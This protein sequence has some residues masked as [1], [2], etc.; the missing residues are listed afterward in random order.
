[1]AYRTFHEGRYVF[2][3]WQH[4]QVADI[5][6]LIVDIAK[7]RRGAGQPLILFSIIPASSDPPSAA[8]RK[9]IINDWATLLPQGETIHAVLEGTGIGASLNRAVLHA[10]RMFTRGRGIGRIYSSLEAALREE[11]VPSSITTQSL[12]DAKIVY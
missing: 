9:R 10:I 4:P 6:S 8:F 3:G 12:R 5:D 7:V 2:I 11:R 1:M